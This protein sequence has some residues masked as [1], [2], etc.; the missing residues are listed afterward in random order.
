MKLGSLLALVVGLALLGLVIAN[1]DVGQVARLLTSLSWRSAA[2]V[3]ALFT[4]AW[5]AEILAWALTFTQRAA[6]GAWLWHLWLVNM[7]GEAMN[8][9]M[10]FGSLGGEPVKAW[11]LKR[12]YLVGYREA[13]RPWC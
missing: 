6:R 5:A 8:V 11:L 13:D 2:A 3:M 9:V 12:H 4:V 7:V 10:P 1:S